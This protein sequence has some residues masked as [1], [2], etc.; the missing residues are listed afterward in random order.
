MIDIN[1]GPRFSNDEILVETSDHA[2]LKLEVG[3]N[4]FFQVNK[5]DQASAATIFNVKDFIGDMCNLMASKVR[6]AVASVDFSTFHKTY[7]RLIRR[8]IFGVNEK[9]KINANLKLEK[10]SLVIFNVDIKN[11][12]PVD[13]QTR[14]SLKK[15][16]FLAI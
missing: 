15:N 16:V 1:L 4:Y 2:V 7:A 8:S 10:N 6:S 9:D 14:E 13:V 3:Y 5:Q 12:D 11:V